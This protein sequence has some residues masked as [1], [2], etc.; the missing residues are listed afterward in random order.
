M[1]IVK[2]GIVGMMVTMSS[3]DGRGRI[4]WPR[5]TRVRRGVAVLAAAL[6]VAAAGCG[7]GHELPEPAE[8]LSGRV[9]S[10]ASLA[11]ALVG[12]DGTVTDGRTATVG[13][14]IADDRSTVLVVTDGVCAG[15][16]E[17]VEGLM[18][19]AFRQPEFSV[20]VLG[21]PE[22]PGQVVEVAVDKGA[23]AFSAETLGPLTED[24]GATSVLTLAVLSPDS[25]VRGVFTGAGSVPRAIDMARG[26]S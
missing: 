3:G 17:A 16:P 14:M 25:V 15:C 4:P 23:A 13:E 6:A 26:G 24:L 9:L 12:T 10:S 5:R 7:D 8:P 1:R 20:I 21:S 22:V 18:A 11:V 2:M 19:E